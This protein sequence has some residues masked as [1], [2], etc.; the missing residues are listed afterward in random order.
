MTCSGC[1]AENDEHR[2]YCGACGAG[3]VRWCSGCSFKNRIIDAFCG[4]CGGK[5][6]EV[7]PMPTSI[8]I[9]TKGPVGVEK[10]APGGMLSLGEVR[11]L[12]TPKA[13]LTTSK[14]LTNKVSQAE[15][16]ALFGT[17]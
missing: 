6:G 17:P 15:L 5:I 16:D 10:P 14:P 12:I 8:R 13:S 2:R 1:R 9:P 7:Q 3:L 11:A 4:G